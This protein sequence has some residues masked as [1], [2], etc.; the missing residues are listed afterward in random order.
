MSSVFIS[1][2]LLVHWL[3][4]V[5][6]LISKRSLYGR[7]IGDLRFLWQSSSCWTGAESFWQGHQLR[8]TV[9]NQSQVE[10]GSEQGPIRGIR[11]TF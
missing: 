10:K 6:V 8:E 4:S 2:A 3:V 7:E 9:L 5:F 1:F 11:N